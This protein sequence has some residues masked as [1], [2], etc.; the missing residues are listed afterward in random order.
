MRCQNSPFRGKIFHYSAG[1]INCIRSP[2]AFHLEPE[3]S[4]ALHTGGAM[5]FCYPPPPTPTRAQIYPPPPTP[6]P[7]FLPSDHSPISLWS[8]QP[9]YLLSVV[10][11]ISFLVFVC[12]Q[13]HSYF[14]GLLLHSARREAEQAFEVMQRTAEPAERQKGLQ[15]L[16]WEQRLSAMAASL[17]QLAPVL[18]V[19]K[20]KKKC[21]LK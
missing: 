15:D 5:L 9:F 12:L 2:L 10:S 17:R 18:A 14:T 11:L 19:S 16:G 6:T 21:L 13:N 4:V 1:T 7:F 3:R 8:K 20:S